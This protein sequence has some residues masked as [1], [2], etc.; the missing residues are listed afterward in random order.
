MLGAEPIGPFEDHRLIHGDPEWPKEIQQAMDSFAAY[1]NSDSERYTARS[2]VRKALATLTAVS[3]PKER[4]EC[5]AILI[6]RPDV[7]ARL[8]EHY[9]TK[10][11]NPVSKPSAQTSLRLLR[12]V[13]AH[14]PK[15]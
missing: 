12:R 14:L 10:A 8:L 4:K 6:A 15:E 2:A 3:K 13:C 9:T 11:V 5:A 1:A 7:Q